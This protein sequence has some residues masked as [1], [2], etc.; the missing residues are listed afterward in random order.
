MLTA[1]G[2]SAKQFCDQ[3]SQRIGAL[4]SAH[5]LVVQSSWQ[6]VDL[7]AL[8]QKQ[9]GFYRDS[10]RVAFDGPPLRLNPEA[11]QAVGMAL[12]ELATNAAKYGALSGAAGRVEIGWTINDAKFA[13]NWSEKGGP[14][15]DTAISRGFGH[16]VTGKMIERAL[17]GHTSLHF[18]STGCTWTLVAPL[19]HAIEVDPTQ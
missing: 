3:F 1:R 9:L 13:L 15:P 17:M 7:R 10:T 2:D 18:P 16:V 5:D 4:A 6:G 19:E 14:S 11:A 8:I 12:H